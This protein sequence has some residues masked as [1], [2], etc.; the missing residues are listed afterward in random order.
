MK[1]IVLCTVLV[2]VAILAQADPK[3][4]ALSIIEHRLAMKNPTNP[5]EKWQS[6]Q[7]L[8]S[9]IG[10]SIHS[11]L[12]DKQKMSMINKLPLYTNGVYSSPSD[13]AKTCSALAKAGP[14]AECF[15]MK[16]MQPP[17]TFPTGDLPLNYLFLSN[18]SL[19]LEGSK[20][21]VAG[22]CN[23]VKGKP[24]TKQSF[25]GPSTLKWLAKPSLRNF[26]TPS[27]AK[28]LNAGTLVFEVLGMPSHPGALTVVVAQ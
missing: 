4:E 9:A 12:V 16:T 3:S 20:H 6:D 17:F 19:A 2:S 15:S 27:G 1:K 24:E 14:S 13:K 28:T 22:D 26:Q 7:W 21:T 10:C 5:F 23:L 18:E 25:A 8:W 11:G